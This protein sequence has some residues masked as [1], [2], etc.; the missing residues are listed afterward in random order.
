MKMKKIRWAVLVGGVFL[1]FVVLA[2]YMTRRG[3][4]DYEDEIEYVI[5]V[6]QANMREAWRVALIQEIEEEAGK[7][8]NIRIVTTDATADVAKQKLDVDNLLQFGIDLLIISPCDTGELTEKIKDVYQG[9]T[10]VI[11]M[12]RGVEG[13]DYSLFIGP[14]N[15]MIGRQAAKCAAELLD[16]QAGTV[17]KLCGNAYSIQSEERLQ[18]FDLI[19]QDYPEIK[20]ETH[21]MEKDLKDTAYD[22]IFS[23]KEKLK[24]IDV[25]FA[26]SDYVA[27][28]AYEALEEMALEKD[29]RIVGCDGFTGKD[30][31]VD[32][33]LQEKIAATISCPTG[34]REAIQYA[35]NILRQES[36]VP[37]QVILRSRTITKENALEYLTSLKKECVD[38]GRTIT[39]GYSQVGQES[40]WRLANTKSIKEAAEE[41]NIYLIFDDANQSQ[42]KQIAAIRRFIREGVDVI[43]VSPVVET[44]WDEVLKEAN[45]AGIPV[46]MS[47]RKVETAENDLTTTYIGADFLEEGRRAMRWIRENVHSNGEKIHIMELKGNEGASPTV[48]RRKGFEEVLKE[49]PDYRIIYSEYGDFTYSGGKKIVEE[50]LR[51]REWDVD[52]IFSHNDDMAMGAIDALENHGISPGKDV[53][54]VS[55]DGTRTAFEA[56]IEGKLNCAV[57]CSPLLGA[58]LMKAIRDMVAGREMPVR[59]ITEEKVYDQS[60]AEEVL[61]QR[62]Y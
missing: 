62:K 29:I 60:V 34:G 5:G 19:M 8:E 16:D 3:R 31:G 55:V 36:G 13:F 52:I 22:T 23:M 43:V 28:G 42:E 33:V 40:E 11:V 54:I 51:N 47:D 41:F 24:K 39:V 12:D 25:I 32:M 26:N 6:S 20:I 1:L 44:G 46:V 37:K 57:E 27:Q 45:I 59:I 14:D 17:L 15:E 50:Y 61:K 30:E 38:D 4:A 21:F 2:F 53:I 35:I 7:Y 49:C 9:G 58:P 18:G 10:P 48:E 56:M